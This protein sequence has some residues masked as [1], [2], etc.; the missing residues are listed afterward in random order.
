MNHDQMMDGMALNDLYRITVGHIEIIEIKIRYH[1]LTVE[2]LFWTS[3][4][5]H[6]II[7]M[8]VTLNVR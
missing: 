6:C 4:Y 3:L 5:K 8:S 2:N 1:L 7:I